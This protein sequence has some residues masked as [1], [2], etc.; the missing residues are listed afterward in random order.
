[1][2]YG[3]VKHSLIETQIGFPGANL[4]VSDN[5]T[6]TGWAA[7]VGAEWA[8]ND[9]WFLGVEYLHV[10]LGSTTLSTPT[11]AVTLGGVIFN[12]SSATFTD[13]S[14]IVRARIDYRFNWSGPIATSH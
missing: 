7:G 8:I 10:D 9:S 11:P 4:T 6:R 2:A 13:R 5:T 3:N 1:L 12:P 14:D